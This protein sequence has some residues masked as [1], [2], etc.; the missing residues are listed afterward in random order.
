MSPFELFDH[1]ADLGLRVR[2]ADLN[3]LFRDAAVGLFAMIV[4]RVPADEP[5][6]TLR[7]RVDG[8]RLDWLL[9]D[10]LNELLFTFESRGLLLHGFEVQVGKERVDAIASAVL[11]DAGKQRALREVKAI[12]YHG[13]RVERI[14]RG[15]IAEVI[16][17]I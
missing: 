4:E 1:T 8:S 2:A 16:V 3:T 6:E 11:F 17:D 9:F 14:E 10:W 7:F 12:T 13:L 15:W 5:G